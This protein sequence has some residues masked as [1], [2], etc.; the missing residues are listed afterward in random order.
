MVSGAFFSIIL[1]G[2]P[3]QPFLPSRGIQQGDPLS[4]FLFVIMVEGLERSLSEAN[5][6]NQLKGIKVVHQGPTLMHQQFVD[7]TI[8]MGTSTVKEARTFSKV[9]R[10]FT[11]AS[12]MEINITKSKLF[13]FNTFIPVQRNLSKI[14]KIERN[15][16]PTKY[17][18]IPLSEYA[19]KAAN[20]EDLLNK[21][22]QSIQIKSRTK[23]SL[24]LLVTLK[25]PPS[26]IKYGRINRL[27]RS[28]TLGSAPRQHRLFRENSW[29]QLRPLDHP[30]WTTLKN[31]M[32]EAGLRKVADYWHPRTTTT[33]WRKWLTKEHCL[34]QDH[35]GNVEHLLQQLDEHKIL[36]S[37]RE[38][39]LRWGNNPKGT[40]N[41][42]EAYKIIAA[43]PEL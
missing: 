18:G 24:G 39:I 27:F 25:V 13:F 28:T 31:E 35:N 37:T 12:S 19:H 36:T 38:D 7:D 40:F 22:N 33:T 16:L 43:S 9:L 32:Q 5:Q 8:L 17:L 29:Q 23:T 34:T 26:G 2:G 10:T 3:L 42:K 30:D 6:T 41:L 4:P 15:S 11:E 14:L 21:M 1:N 20:W